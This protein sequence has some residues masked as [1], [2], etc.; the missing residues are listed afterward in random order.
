MGMIQETAFGLF[1]AE[2][3]YELDT[4]FGSKTFARGLGFD[5][6]GGVQA[7]GNDVW[8]LWLAGISVGNGQHKVQGK[9]QT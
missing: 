6:R 7:V 5:D 9:R 1:T 4:K 2:V 8:Q 3:Q